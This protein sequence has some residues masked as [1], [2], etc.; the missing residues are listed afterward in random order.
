VLTKV[1]GVQRAWWP[2][3]FISWIQH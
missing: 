2:T 1:S 3:L